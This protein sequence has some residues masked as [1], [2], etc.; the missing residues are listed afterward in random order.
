MTDEEKEMQRLLIE[1]A[2][3]K[4]LMVQFPPR[5]Y[6]EIL[7]TTEY[8]KRLYSTAVISLSDLNA[9][10]E[11]GFFTVTIT[12]INPTIFYQFGQ[13]VGFTLMSKHLLK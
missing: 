11:A 6:W 2:G 13:R 1:Q 9:G 5:L 3:L 12:H 7:Q 8:L 10:L 4:T